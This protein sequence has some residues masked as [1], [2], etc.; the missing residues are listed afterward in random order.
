MGLDI[1]QVILLVVVLAAIF[2]TSYTLIMPFFG[3]VYE[4]GFGNAPCNKDSTCTGTS[5][6]LVNQYCLGATIS[7]AGKIACTSCN[8]STGYSGFLSNCYALIDDGTTIN[9]TYCYGCTN[10]GFKSTVSGLY[11]F[12]FF[13][14]MIAFVL[15]FVLKILP[16]FR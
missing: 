6:N 5:T 8:S 4:Y 12:I 13:I 10:W 3:N 7:E 11:L 1:K 14:G 16:K 15:L 2:M 9:N